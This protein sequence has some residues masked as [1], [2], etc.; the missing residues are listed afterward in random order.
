MYPTIQ[1]AAVLFRN[2][3][4][5]SIAQYRLTLGVQHGMSILVEQRPAVVSMPESADVFD[6]PQLTG[7][8]HFNRVGIKQAV[9]SLVA[10]REY[11]IRFFRDADHVF[12]LADVPGH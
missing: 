2:R 4:T 11:S 10:D 3:G 5:P 8:K 1:R 6:V 12:A 9:V 7:A